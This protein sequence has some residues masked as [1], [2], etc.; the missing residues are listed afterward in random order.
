[1]DSSVKVEAA[2]WGGKEDVKRSES[3]R[4]RPNGS[5]KPGTH[6]TPQ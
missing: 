5:D 4:R 6:L 1:M 2:D 3:H